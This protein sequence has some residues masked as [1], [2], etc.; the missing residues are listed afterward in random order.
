MTRIGNTVGWVLIAGALL[1]GDTGCKGASTA[2]DDRAATLAAAVVESCEYQ[3]GYTV[4]CP[5]Y[6]AFLG[7]LNGGSHDYG[8]VSLVEEVK[9]E[10]RWLGATGL[11]RRGRQFEED[12]TLRARLLE[13]ARGEVDS[14]VAKALG[15]AVCR[16]LSHQKGAVD[17]AESAAMSEESA[18]IQRLA[19]EHPLPAMR[20]ALLG[21]LMGYGGDA[22]F[23]FTDVRLGNDSD[24][25]VR[26]AGL[27]ALMT[28]PSTRAAEVCAIWQRH[29]EADPD[30]D[31]AAVAA[32]FRA[33][34]GHCL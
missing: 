3:Q 21:E 33:T 18:A 12:P 10:N 30:P 29:A 14:A 13:A 19:E 15:A 17:A 28:A 32:K 31:T 6:Q 23:D 4:E 1:S 8:L 22:W 16:T 5:A 9:P 27:A 7:G 25:R 11:V 20:A 34:W 24:V 26:R 2:R